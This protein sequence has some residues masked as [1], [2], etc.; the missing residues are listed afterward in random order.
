M[1]MEKNG[2]ELEN[3]PMPTETPE[4]ET[5]SSP[6]IPL[7]AEE[8]PFLGEG[9]VENA[10]ISEENT[11]I[12][13]EDTENIDIS[14]ENLEDSEP[15]KINFVELWNKYRDSIF[16]GNGLAKRLIATFLLVTGINIVK[17][18]TKY[19]IKPMG[20][21][22]VE[23]TKHNT[24][25]EI[26]PI[27]ALI[28]VVFSAIS[29][30]LYRK[31]NLK[32][33]S[34]F[35]FISTVFFG[36]NALGQSDDVYLGF[37]ISAF[38][39]G[40][41]LLFLKKEDFEHLQ[42]LPR[43]TWKVLVFLLF[44]A[45]T[46]FIAITCVYGY[47]NYGKSTFDL[48]IFV[49]MFHSLSNDFDFITTCERDQFLSH[50]HVHFSWGYIFLLP[51]YYFFP[52]PETLLILQP[53]LALG[54]VIPLWLICKKYKYSDIG[55]ALFSIIYI[56]SNSIVMPN[57][58]DFH[59]NA[60]LPT[61]LL[62]FIYAVEKRKDILSLIMLVVCLSIKEDA[63]LYT[64]CIG[65]YFLFRNKKE[66]EHDLNPKH[67]REMVLNSLLIIFFSVSYFIAVMKFMENTG[68]G[69]L[70]SVR[71]GNLMTEQD[72]GMGNLLV[73]AIQNPVNFFA[74]CFEE[75]RLIFTLQMLLPLAFIPFVTKRINRFALIIPFILFNLASG[76][77]YQHKIDFQ[78]VY[79]TGALFIY[80]AVVNLRDFKP[81]SRHTAIISMA[82]VSVM[83]CVSILTPKISSY[84]YYQNNKE[85]FQK[86]DSYLEQIP[87]DASVR[88]ETFLLPH[89]ANRTEIYML[90]DG[91]LE[92]DI[93]EDFVA[94]QDNNSDFSRKMK[95]HLA[96]NGY[97]QW[98]GKNGYIWVY[99]NPE[100]LEDWYVSQ[101]PEDFEE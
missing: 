2:L 43:F 80:L 21:K 72:G 31:K 29:V 91:D 94:I 41:S 97:K 63:A 50:L 75:E 18:F 98:K 23:F 44:A 36:V 78:Y 6:E 67:H 47:L 83:T 35:L 22:W 34:Y 14:E 15:E 10:D 28:F 96:E 54:G 48:G 12:S 8:Q 92:R 73:T 40:I 26:I 81:K 30:F 76:W 60:M 85:R 7:N 27:F 69:T 32:F 52:S 24:F 58:Y 37:S 88:S 84:E 45:V 42:K 64:I 11:V 100:Y 93:E 62:W 66:N 87:Q 57:F 77:P 68:E 25:K 46:A 19:D 56:F 59:E 16:I 70:L 55:T 82:L 49:Q 95:K 71:Y 86:M 89:I 90:D 61:A 1:E 51:F 5:D 53:I 13:A 65:I 33:D 39:V 101:Y 79:G 3:I 74:Q 38:C 99:I 4:P 20:E 9:N 17:T